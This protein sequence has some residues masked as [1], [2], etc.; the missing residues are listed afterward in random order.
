VNGLR[1]RIR[2]L[3]LALRRAADLVV[4]RA[5]RLV[6]R[7]SRYA[8][9]DEGYA[10]RSAEDVARE[11][12]QMKGAVM[13]LGQMLS[14]VVDGLPPEAQAA[15]AQLQANAPPMAPSLAAGVIRDELGADPSSLFA[16]WDPVPVA[17]ASIGQVHRAAMADGREV[18]VKVQYPGIDEAIGRDLADARRLGALLGAVTLRGVDVDEL[19]AELRDRMTDE[20]DYRIEAANQ[21]AF[22]DRYRG[23]PFLTVPDVVAERSA[24]RVLTSTWVGGLRFAELR[25]HSDQ[26]ERDRAGEA[27]FRFAQGSVLRDRLF[28]GD[29]HPGNYRFEADG[30][31]TVLDFG[32]VK[33][34]D[35]ADFDVL[36][37]V[38][39]GV[40]VQDEQ[41]TTDA[42]VAAGFLEPDH[43]LAPDRVFACVSAPYRAYFDE[44]F[45]FTPAYTSDALRSLLDVR[46]PY[47]DV[48]RALDMPPSFVMLDRLVWGVSAVLG[49]LGA[50]GAW[51]GI[52]AEYRE[53]AAPA[54]AMGR[55]E[56]AWRTGRSDRPDRPD[57]RSD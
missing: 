18:A 50:T 35:P 47:A 28:N 2:L 4:T 57:R 16:R 25:A 38:L 23:H 31:V 6:T 12:G 20:L 8:E 40:L 21:Q 37:A 9:L 45:T 29:P 34:L 44:Q 27:I 43:G 26:A 24:R 56:A 39:D 51:R 3:G 41:A 22:A 46:G 33:R 15:L 11:L 5:R 52:V 48:L 30:T 55:A 49:Q 13:K 42:M 19:A 32:L 17:A 7:R 36:M 10:L 1:R 14:F 54:T 53:G